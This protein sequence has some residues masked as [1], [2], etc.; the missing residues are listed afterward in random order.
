MSIYY[1]DV[2]SQEYNELNIGSDRISGERLMDLIKK[3]E[4]LS[5]LEE[6][7]ILNPN[8]KERKII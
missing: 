5:E 7:S 3:R 1:K 8:T 6:I 2:D 4:N